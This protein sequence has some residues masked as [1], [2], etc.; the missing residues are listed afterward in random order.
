MTKPQNKTNITLEQA[1][2]AKGKSNLS[3][4]LAE[5]QK[6]KKKKVPK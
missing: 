6:E 3:K 4:L 5:Q 1:K 2:K